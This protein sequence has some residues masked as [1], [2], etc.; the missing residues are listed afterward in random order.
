MLKDRR[1]D[2]RGMAASSGQPGVHMALSHLLGSY[3]VDKG[4]PSKKGEG[5][6]SETW[7]RIGNLVDQK[8]ESW[9][10]KLAIFPGFFR[11]CSC[12]LCFFNREIDCFHKKSIF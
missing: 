2:Y 8:L 10:Q 6:G 9:D 11:V 4:P 3:Q 5:E 7:S 12:F 1:C